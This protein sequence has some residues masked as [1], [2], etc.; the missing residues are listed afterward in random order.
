MGK[1]KRVSHIGVAVKSLEESIPFY[2][3][4]LGLPLEDQPLGCAAGPAVLSGNAKARK[5]SESRGL[6][7]R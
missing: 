7:T 5:A 2:R 1:I 6:L 4:T 3:D